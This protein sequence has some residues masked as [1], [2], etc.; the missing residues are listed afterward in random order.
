M[1]AAY[2]WLLQ[3]ISLGASKLVKVTERCEKACHIEYGLRK[4]QKARKNRLAG[5]VMNWF[6][7]LCLSWLASVSLIW[8]TTAPYKSWLDRYDKYQK[9]CAAELQSRKPSSTELKLFEAKSAMTELYVVVMTLVEKCHA[10]NSNP[11]NPEHGKLDCQGIERQHAENC[12]GNMNSCA[13]TLQDLCP[14]SGSQIDALV[15]EIMKA[16]HHEQ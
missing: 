6:S 15:S 5:G 7:I 4:S 3:Y 9:Q 1:A 11:K 13:Y 16:R 12:G 2:C 8:A 14:K 10:A